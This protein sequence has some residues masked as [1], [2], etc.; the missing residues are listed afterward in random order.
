MPLQHQTH[1]T[2]VVTAVNSAKFRTIF[3][4][5]V[6]VYTITCVHTMKSLIYEY[7]CEEKEAKH[8]DSEI[9]RF[10]TSMC[11]KRKLISSKLKKTKDLLG[12]DCTN[13]HLYGK[14]S[15]G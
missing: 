12:Q 3:E 4:N 8:T 15:T 11:K 5:E 9:Y 2:E 7:R 13:I 1:C 14:S 6:F 10:M